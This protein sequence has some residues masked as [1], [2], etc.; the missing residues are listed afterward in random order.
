[1]SNKAAGRVSPEDLRIFLR[2][3]QHM[4]FSE[5]AAQMGLPKATVSMAVKR[6]E[7]RVG[8]R[9]LQRTTRRVQLTTDG[10]AFVRRGQDV[11][12]D[13]DELEA[14]FHSDPA[15][16]AGRL[17]VDM[18]LGMARELVMPR[19]SE[20]LLKH[21]KLSLELS[22]TDRRVEPI[23]EGHDCVLRVGSLL[24]SSLVA[25]PVGRLEQINCLGASYVAR[26]GTPRTLADLS[27]HDLVHYQ[28]NLGDKCQG[29]EH[30]DPATGALRQIAMGGP[31]SVN[32]SDAY[33]AACLGGLGLIQV[34]RHSVQAL[35]A[36]ARLVEVL[37][38][39]RPPAMPISL[40]YP[41][42]RQIPARVQAFMY[43]VEMVL[44]QALGAP[45]AGE[46]R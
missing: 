6:L 43:W 3:A 42:R 35:L 11:L 45:A 41:Q 34:P 30:V 9:L 18:P 26:R 23:R 12:D 15:N 5:A 31:L 46:D 39:H 25:R 27:A 8:V 32:N 1:M 22:S 19:L 20:F 38:E 7:W 37:P 13:L 16:L 4:S 29:F 2:V 17:R 36:S 40:L 10:Q 24:D 44:A 14:M 28:P 21:P 33:L